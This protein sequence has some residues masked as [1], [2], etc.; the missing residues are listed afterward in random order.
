MVRRTRTTVAAL[1][2]VFSVPVVLVGVA[3]ACTPSGYG[4]P[5]T[6]TAPPASTGQAAPATFGNTDTGR[7]ERRPRGL[8]CGRSRPRF[9]SGRVGGGGSCEH[10][11]GNARAFGI[12][13][14]Q[15]RRP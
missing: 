3:M 5:A 11:G 14:D 1:T 7:P 6:P 12:R 8:G 4:T 2:G 9:G 15:R 10:A 13:N